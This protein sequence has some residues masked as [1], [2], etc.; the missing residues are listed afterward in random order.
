MLRQ[1]V[2]LLNC[3]FSEIERMNKYVSAL[4]VALCCSAS[5]WAGE[6]QV[7][8]AWARATAPGQD[9]AAIQLTLTS[10]KAGAVVGGSSKVAQTVE[11]H[12]MVM[13]GNMMKM[14]ALTELPLP[15]NAAVSLAEQG[16]HVMLIGLK[17]ALKAGDK[18]AFVLAVKFSDGSKENV[19]VEAE[20][21]PL[22]TSDSMMHEHHHHHHH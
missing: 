10:K 11:I 22:G 5:A 14:R 19:A 2:V 6:V 8:D 12:S 15:A 13:E 9:S 3:G 20:I 17:Q 16:N 7:S 4:M 1:A 18:V 21:R